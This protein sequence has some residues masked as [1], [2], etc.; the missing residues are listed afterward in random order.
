[1]SLAIS[2]P[3]SDRTL[4]SLEEAKVALGITGTGEDASLGILIE[5]ISDAIA[6]D[7]RVAM[8][9]NVPPT[10]RAETLVETLRVEGR[11]SAILTSR[12][13][14]DPEAVSIVEAGS[15]LADGEFEV[16]ASA[17]MITRL[18]SDRAACWACGK[19]VVTY[20]AGFDV[21]PTDLKRAVVLALR[22]Q[23]AGD[24]HDP[25]LKRE[26]V[27]GLG[28]QEFWIGG[29]AK[30]GGGAFSVQVSEMLAP[31]RATAIG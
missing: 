30:A 19:I 29:L 4:I 23:R 28:E 20:T 24:T 14:I 3:A 10:L 13:F 27:D 8:A 15:D 31:Y 11:Q 17:G 25:L 12:R 6:Q 7:C 21:V 18:I 9:G 2:I 16:D 22:E 26:D 1:M 5:S